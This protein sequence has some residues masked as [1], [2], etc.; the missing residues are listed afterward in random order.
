[1]I[2]I[3]NHILIPYQS[4]IDEYGRNEF[5]VNFITYKCEKCNNIIFYY[6]RGQIYWMYK[7]GLDFNMGDSWF[8]LTLTCEEQMIKNLLE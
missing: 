7:N 2:N 3:L 6:K 4:C 1:M 5:S 8:E